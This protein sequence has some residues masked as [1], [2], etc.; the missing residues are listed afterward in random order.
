MDYYY[1]YTAELCSILGIW[2]ILDEYSPIEK[3]SKIKVSININ[4]Q[5]VINALNKSDFLVQFNIHLYQI[6][7]E[8][9][10][11]ASRLKARVELMKVKAYQDNHTP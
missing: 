11:I 10:I 9:G 8:I 2:I 3:I 7:R 5:A 1:S 6:R 4:C